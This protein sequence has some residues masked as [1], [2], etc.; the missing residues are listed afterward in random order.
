M[1]MPKRM[2][3]G[4]ATFGDYFD[5]TIGKFDL[6]DVLETY[7]RL[8]LSPVSRRARHG[9]FAVEFVAYPRGDK[10]DIQTTAGEAVRHMR[11]HGVVCGCIG[12]DDEY[13]YWLVRSSQWE[14]AKWLLNDSLG[15]QPVRQPKTSWK[16][17][18]RR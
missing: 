2:E 12:F 18:R 5:A 6:L 3:T 15:A 14:W 16:K 8:A 4:P 7:V 13:T 11:A 17:R 9:R 1:E 10:F